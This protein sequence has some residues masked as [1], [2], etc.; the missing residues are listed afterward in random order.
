MKNKEKFVEYEL[1]YIDKDGKEKETT[2]T[3]PENMNKPQKIL[4][5]MDKDSTYFKLL[6]DEAFTE[7]QDID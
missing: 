3:G 2:I 6:D 1:K 4:A 7:L 5:L